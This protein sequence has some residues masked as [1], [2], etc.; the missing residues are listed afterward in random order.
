MLEA[1]NLCE[2]RAHVEML[3]RTG[4]DLKEPHQINTKAGKDS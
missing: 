2:M 1:S 4:G 3:C